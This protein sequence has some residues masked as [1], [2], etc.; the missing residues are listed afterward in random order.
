MRVRFGQLW[1]DAVTF[2]QALDE[3][4]RL[5]EQRQGGSVF[6]PNVDHVGKGDGDA[7]FRAAYERASLSLA[8]GQPVVWASRLLGAPLPAKVS[9]SGLGFP[10]M[11][12]G[13]EKGW[14]G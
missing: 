12:R 3:I 13:G 1:V 8:D 11:E 7:V 4:E 2:E 14:R 6:T 5:V 9:G 10:L